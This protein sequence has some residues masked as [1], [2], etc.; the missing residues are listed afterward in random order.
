V[1]KTSSYV[2][3]SEEPNTSTLSVNRL[4][5]KDVFLI[6]DRPHLEDT[7]VV[8]PRRGGGHLRQCAE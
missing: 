8:V 1:A 7:F 6:E 2:G 3:A 5:I 4:S